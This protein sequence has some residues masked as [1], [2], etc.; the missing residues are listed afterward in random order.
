MNKLSELDEISDLLFDIKDKIKDNNYLRIFNL[1]KTIKD[2][3][4][5]NEIYI[6]KLKI[7]LIKLKNELNKLI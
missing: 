4:Y 3:N 6:N 2:N 1:I 5:Q 7:L